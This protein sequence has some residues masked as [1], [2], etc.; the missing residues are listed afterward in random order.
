MF[1]NN[2]QLDKS[3]RISKTRQEKG[4]FLINGKILWICC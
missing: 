2:E 3:Y 4:N 1:L